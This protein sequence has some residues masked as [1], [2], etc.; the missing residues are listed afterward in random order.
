MKTPLTMTPLMQR[1]TMIEH[2]ISSIEVNYVGKKLGE[3]HDLRSDLHCCTIV[4]FAV[5]MVLDMQYTTSG[6]RHD[7][8]ET[9]KIAN[10]EFIVLCCEVTESSIRHRL[11]TARLLQRISN[12][13][14]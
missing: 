13:Q 9:R 1:Y 8:V 2:R 11:T 3:L 5:K 12:I 4:L 6:R 7:V 10:E 14:S